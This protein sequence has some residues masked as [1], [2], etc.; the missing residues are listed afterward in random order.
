MNYLKRFTPYVIAAFLL[1]AVALFIPTYLICGTITKPTTFTASTVIKSAEVNENFD[2]LYSEINGLLDTA[3]FE[4]GGIATEDLADSCVTDTKITTGITGTKID[5]IM[6]DSGTETMAGEK[7]FSDTITFND[8][9]VFDSRF[10]HGLDV[11]DAPTDDRELAP[12]KYVDDEV[13]AAIIRDY[14]KVSD[15]KDSNTA[16]GTF[17]AGA[18]QTRTIN[19]EDSDVS[20]ICSVDTVLDRITLDTGTYECEIYALAYQVNVHQAIL[21]D[22]T[23]SDTILIGMN[24]IAYHTGTYTGTYSVITGKFIIA[25]QTVFEIR[26]YCGVTAATT[27]FG[28]PVNAPDAS[29]VYTTAVFRRVAK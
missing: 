23:N 2:T 26:H 5:N 20:G 4:N 10:F 11:Y 29:E 24:A 18:W 12:K 1:S 22:V 17:T 9:T 25:A 8:D 7:T 28:S 3:N 16:G 27:G 6:H 15:T 21:Y 19:T 13:T 14:V